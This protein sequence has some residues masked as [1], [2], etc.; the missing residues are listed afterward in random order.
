MNKNKTIIVISGLVDATI[1][2][3]QPDVEFKMFKNIDGLVDYLGANPIRA[4]LLFFTYD[5]VSVNPNTSF[6]YLKDVLE[7]NAYINVDKVVYI[8]E[9]HSAELPSL[10]YLIDEYQLDNW[11]IVT[12]VTSRAFIHEVINGTFREETLNF[13]R[14]VVVRRPR[15]DYIKQQLKTQT[16]LEEPYVDD[17][18]DLQDIP[19]EEIP[20]VPIEERPSILK[21]VYIAGVPCKERTAFSLLMAQY[22]S[23]TDKTLIIESDP[24]FHMLT[25]FVT[26]AKIPCTVVTITDIYEDPARAINNMIKAENNLVVV[27]C[28]D[29]IPFDY[30][31][32][33]SLLY[34]NLVHDFKYLI[35]E[36]EINELP[37]DSDVTIVMPSTIPD[38]LKTGELIDKSMIDRCHFVGVDMQELPE[39]HVSSGLVL[40]KIL[41][42]ILTEDKVVC[43]VITIS[44]L[45]LDGTIYDL[46][47]IIGRGIT[48]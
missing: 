13:K 11:E 31:Y 2:E 24:D 41:Q 30:R 47:S 22:L 42:D 26:K 35:T 34:Y 4:S 39:V 9:D 20:V 37:E 36:S 32:I 7:T 23:M 46:G 6:M 14:K 43:P 29:R 21:K 15:E 19:D 5:V 44:S 10:N 3:Y 1:K 16:S 12:G 8:T 45:R 17:D 25:E 18:Q 38:I 40:G 48:A 28:I 27:E 33:Q